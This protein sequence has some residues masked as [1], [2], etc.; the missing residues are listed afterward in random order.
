[1]SIEIEPIEENFEAVGELMEQEEKKTLSLFGFKEQ[2][3]HLMGETLTVVEA[4]L[5]DPVQRKAVKDLI[6]H[7]FYNK[8]HWIYE[9]CSI[10]PREVS[11]DPHVVSIAGDIEAISEMKKKVKMTVSGKL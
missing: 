8:M 6:K 7:N 5:I 2:L 11:G 4:A 1:M 10:D 3:D 9:V